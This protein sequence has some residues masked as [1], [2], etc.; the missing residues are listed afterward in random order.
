MFPIMGSEKPVETRFRERVFAERKRRDWSQADVAT[1]LRDKGIQS[2]YPTTIAKIESGERAVRIDEASALADIFEVSLDTLLGRSAAPNNDDMYALRAL[3]DATAN[4]SW[5]VSTIET[6]LRDRI[7][8]VAAFGPE[9]VGKTIASGCERAADALAAADGALREVL[10]P[11]GSEGVQR[12]MRKM[13]LTMLQKE[14]SDD[15]TQ[16]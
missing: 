7:A 2:I 5:Q 14:E 13:M 6:T 9:G 10:N 16:P 1:M 12:A 3:V 11:P 4:A 15:E 8:E